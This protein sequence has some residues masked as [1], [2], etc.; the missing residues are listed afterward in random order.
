[1]TLQ[2]WEY[3]RVIIEVDTSPDV[4]QKF[5]QGA[6][7]FFIKTKNIDWKD[8]E[9]RNLGNAGWELVSTVPITGGRVK[10][11]SSLGWGTSYTIS[12]C[13]LF[14]RPID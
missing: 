1:M 7:A 13:L 4:E 8:E 12:I 14:K 2:R 6:V 9:I 10:E 5:L 11:S 3:K